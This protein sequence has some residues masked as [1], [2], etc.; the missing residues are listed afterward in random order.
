MILTEVKQEV[1][2]MIV[3]HT[4]INALKVL[5]TLSE[6]KQALLPAIAEEMPY[7]LCVQQVYRDFP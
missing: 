2:V 5:S 3:L 6:T 4:N 1:R 7:D